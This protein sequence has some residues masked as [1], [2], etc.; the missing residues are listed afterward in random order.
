MLV[1]PIMGPVMGMT[2]GARIDDWR[3]VRSSFLVETYSILI[4]FFVGALIT[5]CAGW[6][7]LADTWPTNEMQ[8]RGET[9][10]LV[11]GIAIAIPSGMGVALSI[12]G[13]NT[14]SLVGVAIS[15]SLLPPAVNAGICWMYAILMLFGANTD[16]T[17]DGADYATIGAISFTL[18]VLNIVCIWLSGMLMF[19]IK[20]SCRR[21]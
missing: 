20:V 18:T 17:V 9:S 21:A 6:T 13:N 19:T 3:L 12:L 4:C 11:I 15:A 14:G 16:D 10:G 7:E 2:F 8:I 5:L 1:S